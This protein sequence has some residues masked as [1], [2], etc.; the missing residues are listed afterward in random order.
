[1][2]GRRHVRVL[3]LLVTHSTKLLFMRT[4]ASTT[5]SLH[6]GRKTS[7]AIKTLTQKVHLTLCNKLFS[8]NPS[9]QSVNHKQTCHLYDIITCVVF[10]RADISRKVFI[11]GN[12]VLKARCLSS[13]HPLLYWSAALIFK[14]QYQSYLWGQSIIRGLLKNKQKNIF[15]WRCILWFS[16]FWKPSGFKNNRRIIPMMKLSIYSNI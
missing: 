11:H 6:E 15:P 12:S 13:T 14:D 4:V 3:S 16:R 8:S 2:W 5:T 9:P 10:S 7:K 1:M